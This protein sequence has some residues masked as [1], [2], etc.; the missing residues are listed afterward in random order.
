MDNLKR[1]GF[2]RD[3]SKGDSRDKTKR[4]KFDAPK[5]PMDEYREEVVECV[6]GNPSSVIIGETG[7]GKTTRIPGFLLDTFPNAKIAITQ[8]RRV[9]ARSV[10]RYVASQ[11]GGNVGEEI[12]Y[13]VRF[14]DQTTK[15][16]RANFMTD[17]ILLRKLQ[18][19]PLLKEFDI[20]MVDEAHERSLNIDFIL[21]LLKRTQAERKKLGLPELK[22]IATSATIE[23]EKF[24]NFFGEAPVVEVPG[25]MYP[26][27]V[28]YAKGYIDD[29]TREAA[30]VVKQIVESGKDGDV[31]IFMPGE[32]EIKRTIQQIEELNLPGIDAMPLFGSMSPEDQDK[33][34]A[35]NPNRKVIVSTNI[36]ETSL[37]IDGVSFV[38]DSGVI[39]QKEF[40]PKTGIE[41]LVTEEHAKSGCEQRKGRAGRTAPG[42]CYRLYTEREYNDRQPFQ[43]P[44]IARSNLDHVILAMKKI[45]IEDVRNFDFIDKPKEETFLRAIEVLQMLGA[46][47]ENEKITEIGETMAD[48]PLSPELARMVIESEKY[49]CTGSIVTIAAMSGDRSVFV[50]PKDKEREADRAHNEFKKSGSDFL[51]LLEVGRQWSAAGFS[52]KWAREKFLN[53]R[54]LFEVKE[55]RGQLM[56]ELKNKGIAV[57]DIKA[58]DENI[59]KS[60]AAGL[61][62]NLLQSAGRHAYERVAGK[63]I[64][65]IYVHPSSSSFQSQ[66]QLIIG[67][68]IV[69]TSKSYAR[70]CQPVD[71]NWLPDIAPHLLTQNS[72]GTFYN[73]ENDCV[74]ERVSY[75]FKGE[76]NIVASRRYEITDGAVASEEFIRALVDGRVDM[77]CVKYNAEV[78]AILGSL[79]SRSGGTLPLPDL[80][81]FYEEKLGGIA[82]K[83][84]A[85]YVS[86]QLKLNV[87]DY[88][89]AE[90]VAEI[91][92]K[93]PETLMVN[94]HELT[95]SY[96]YRAADPNSHYYNQ[97][98]E[99]YHA[100]ILIPKEGLFQL[101]EEEIPVI[102]EDSR[103]P[104]NYKVVDGH[105]VF[106]EEN[107]EN[108]KNAFSVKSV[109]RAWYNF[110]KPQ[111]VKVEAVAFERLPSFESLGAKPLVY[112]KDYLGN[113]VFAYPGYVCSRNY[114]YSQGEYVNFYT[115]EYFKKEKDAEVSTES[116]F[117][118]KNEFDAEQK[119]KQEREHLLDPAQKR[120]EEITLL[121][122]SV[123]KDIKSFGVSKDDWYRLDSRYWTVY[124]LLNT[125]QS[126]PRKAIE[127]IDAIEN[128]LTLSKKELN[129][130]LEIVEMIKPEFERIADKFNNMNSMSYERFGLTYSQYSYIVD[131]WREA[132]NAIKSED[133]YGSFVMP[134][135]DR[136][137][138]LMYE[139]EAM[140]PEQLESTPEQEALFTLMTGRDSG[141][142][143][144]IRVRG[145]RVTEYTS[146]KNPND[147]TPNPTI[148]DIGK[149]GR[150]LAINGRTVALVYGGGSSGGQFVLNDGEYVFGRDACPVV[151]VESKDGR[152]KA[153]EFI[154]SSEQQDYSS[155]YTPEPPPVVYG[156]SAASASLGGLS[157]TLKGFLGKKEEQQPARR[158]LKV[159]TNEAFT[160]EPKGVE[161]EREQMTE[162]LRAELDKILQR[163]RVFVDSVRSTPE[164]VNKKDPNAGKISKLIERAQKARE[165]INEL[166]RDL[167]K[168]TDAPR[169]RGN[170]GAAARQ[171]EKNAAE[172][173]RL[174]NERTDWTER[175]DVF[176]RRIKDLAEVLEVEIDST[177]EGKI[178]P[179]IIQLAKEKDEEIAKEK[180]EEMDF[181]GELET[182]L[183]DNI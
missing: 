20:V 131:K 53:V 41:A 81:L 162:E 52:D 166:K 7:S 34:F 104:V 58:T 78:L 95:V 123:K 80:A 17:G 100:T 77:P 152:L 137:L 48:L 182:I 4:S 173:A 165:E 22:V 55:I 29:Y 83:S 92:K 13:Q 76:Y 28:K 117:N 113:D 136:A 178:R 141:F 73:P 94:G 71:S 31:L 96:E 75:K 144:L 38:V 56:R 139:V 91:D 112:A 135:P 61:V 49:G 175:Y 51:S 35:K 125:S 179:L 50:R 153:L 5:V 16:T 147:V 108:L 176:A 148:I 84:N 116:A 171:A 88:I 27:E 8:P 130:R 103:P 82:S 146:P 62:H 119:L 154:K 26:V 89:S 45:G 32:G 101:K 102:G 183:V 74:E 143:K 98:S 107:L 138:E 40:N 155:D 172:M 25:R 39:K 54:Q 168:A 180:D 64:G 44:E 87:G 118:R 10:A 157:D 170:I 67:S 46:L 114:D 140:I 30:Q 6:K 79:T 14:E 145:G 18:F 163:T 42:T 66:P 161:V 60:V 160:A 142:S 174:L 156:D 23:K 149:S 133:R 105:D 159:V 150:H 69:S 177:L 110:T 134:D 63:S 85:L 3:G 47:D 106:I 151:R 111:S 93:Y 21:G 33:I 43:K 72:A 158:V 164:P 121:F 59:Q 128:T 97:R 99:K 65:R 12:G 15:G 9:A 120:F 68:N 24:A 2:T 115:V 122:E 126:D 169:F 19:D 36:A 37:T 127:E 181:D 90:L 86:E 1:D 124:N 167:F 132:S 109:D 129:R 11:R 57:E 70:M